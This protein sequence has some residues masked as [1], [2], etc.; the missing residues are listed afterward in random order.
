MV[1]D[2]PAVGRCLKKSKKCRRGAGHSICF[3]SHSLNGTLCKQTE[4]VVQTN[5]NLKCKD[6]NGQCTTL[7]LTPKLN[8]ITAAF[9]KY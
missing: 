4:L 8:F 7:P 5:G 2:G 9:Y 6:G 1:E 3:C